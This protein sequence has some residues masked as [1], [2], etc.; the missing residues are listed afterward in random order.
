LMKMSLKNLK[1]PF[2]VTDVIIEKDK[3][4]ILLRRNIEPYRGKLTFP[5]GFVEYGETVEHAAVRETIEETGL[6][7]KLKEI[8]GVYSNPKRDPRL[9]SSTVVFIADVVS[10]KLKK[11]FEGEPDWYPLNKINFS[12]MGFDH[13][14]ILKDYIKWRESKGTFWTS[15]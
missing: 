6:K 12:D 11:S 4:I 8:L 15:K 14:K 9:H 2:T 5:A 10:G 13:G 1:T 7:V 3:K